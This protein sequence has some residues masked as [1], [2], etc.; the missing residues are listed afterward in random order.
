MS[1]PIETTR[2]PLSGPIIQARD[3]VKIFKTNRVLDGITMDVQEHE[4][5][6][7]IGASGSGKSTLLRCLNGLLPIEAGTITVADREVTRDEID[8]NLLRRDVG[9]VFQ[10]YNLFPH[11]SVMKNITLGPCRVLGFSR[12]AAL[13]T[14]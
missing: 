11:M 14:A 8:L 12:A 5:V 7:L 6:A 10:S 13:I 3:V 1:L 9:M 2:R 4:V